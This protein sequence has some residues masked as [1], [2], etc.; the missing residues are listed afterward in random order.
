MPRIEPRALGAGLALGIALACSERPPEPTATAPESPSARVRPVDPPAA[1]GAS[2][3]SLASD[4]DRVMAT[5]IEPSSDGAHRVRFARLSGERWTEPS[6]VIESTQLLVNWADFPMPVRAGSG[7]YLVTFSMRGTERHASSV[8]LARSDDGVVWTVLGA[9]H[10]DDTQTEH[11]FVSLVPERDGARA[12]WLDGR[13]MVDGGPMTLRTAR[14]T[15]D[16]VITD[17]AVLD[18]RTCDCCQTTAVR[19]AE[20]GVLV[21]YRDR[22]DAELRDVALVRRAGGAWTPPTRVHEDGWTM[23]GCPVNGPQASADG[24]RVAIAWYTEAGGDPRVRVAFSSDAGATFGA[25]IELDDA[26][27]LGRVDVEWVG[28]DAWVSWLGAGEREGEAVV[29]VRRVASDRRV[30]AALEIARTAAARASGFPRITRAGAR[31][32]V[33][34]TDVGP[35]SRVRAALVDPTEVPA[36]A[37][38]PARRA[39]RAAEPLTLGAT[40]PS[41]R[42]TGLD[43]APVSLESLRGRPIVIAFFASWCEPCRAEYPLLS[44][45]AREHGER[46]HVVGVSLDDAPIDRVA[47]M[48]RE[49]AL[50]YTVLQD[51][52]DA[53][54]RAFGVP[55]IPATFVFDARGALVY[56]RIGGGAE[57]ERELGAIVASTVN[58]SRPVDAPAP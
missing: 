29:R 38:P 48:A 30:G 18:P 50:E 53:A 37:T 47:Q 54:T 45:L 2:A 39:S 3:P 52:D 11:G 51:R 6:T 17:R 19:T 41:M 26:R 10:D 34:W 35:P 46:V 49:D 42:L 12:V 28:A 7:A 4:G 5:W 40:L 9:L 57:L 20:G 44:R 25:P 36:P 24:R 56:R 22:S 15:S 14:I 1:P 32:L 58:G 16:G 8:E 31:V 55:P 27:P 21:A 13:E 43:G 33:A 23:P